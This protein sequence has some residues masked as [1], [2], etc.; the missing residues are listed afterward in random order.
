MVQSTYY[1]NLFSSNNRYIHTFESNKS[2][3]QGNKY[4][5]FI[6]N[7]FTFTIRYYS[8]YSV[9]IRSLFGHYSRLFA[10]FGHC[11]SLFASIRDYSRLFGT[12]HHYSSLFATIRTIRSLFGFYHWRMSVPHVDPQRNL[13]L[14]KPMVV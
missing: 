2:W 10:P 11:L 13:I 4:F 1:S 6:I 9:T 12:I 7:S 14:M 3:K 5:C 8:L